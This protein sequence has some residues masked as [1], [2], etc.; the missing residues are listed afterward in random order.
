MVVDVRILPV[1]DGGSQYVFSHGEEQVFAVEV[2]KWYD[3]HRAATSI[4]YDAA[5]GMHEDHHL[6]T[7]AVFE[8]G[9]RL[10]LECVS[11]I[12]TQGR[13]SHL[14]SDYR[15]LLIPNG[16]HFFGHGHTHALHDTM[17]FD[18]A[19]DSFDRNFQLMSRWGLNPK[20]YAYPGSSGKSLR[21]QSA[22]RAAGFI[23]AR[24][25]HL[26]PE[27]ERPRPLEGLLICPDD[28]KEPKNWQYLPSVV[29]GTTYASMIAD[30]AE[31][32]PFL[33]KAL[34]KGAWI[35]MMYH[36]IG[37]P[38]LW[39]YYPIEEFAKDLDMMKAND[40][41]NGN[42]DSIVLYI[43]ERN[44]FRIDLLGMEITAGLQ[45]YDLAFSDGLDNV[46][47]DQPLTLNFTFAPE[48]IV[49]TVRFE[50]PLGELGELE[51]SAAGL[52][53]SVNVAP[54]ERPYSLFIE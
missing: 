25:D 5:W 26:N 33:E 49:R 19:Y 1:D 39:G 12:F 45:H 21:T 2:A 20:V 35:I 46:F 43:Q 30:H 28:V 53:F 24:G 10:D 8:R 41:W 9:M 52:Q 37:I 4:T 38:E 13:W 23:A 54:D 36:G 47:Y 42:M 14:I 48:E 27:T 6:A 32:T 44:R 16:V 40:F 51:V 50:P 17:E 11:A 29:M 31:L 34:E 15:R 22:N 7:D 3:N 18:E